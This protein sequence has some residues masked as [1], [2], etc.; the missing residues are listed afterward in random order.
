MIICFSRVIVIVVIFCIIIVIGFAFWSYMWEGDF[1]GKWASVVTIMSLIG[2][3]IT[4]FSSQSQKKN[5]RKQKEQDERNCASG[6]LY[7]E[8]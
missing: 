2:I 6:N 8:L 4:Y 5:E 1:L 3:P 7:R